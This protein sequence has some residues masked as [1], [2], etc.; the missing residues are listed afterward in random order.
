MSSLRPTAALT[1]G[2]LV[3]VLALGAALATGRVQVLVLGL[4]MLAW[5]VGA[6]AEHVLRRPSAARPEVRLRRATIP[7]QATTAVDVTAPAGLLVSTAWPPL[8][9]LDTAP[10]GRASV[11]TPSTRLR[12]T[13]RRW[14]RYELGPVRT[15]LTDPWGAFRHH[16]NLAC[17]PL[18]VVPD[19][20]SLEAGLEVP[21]PIGMSGPHLSRRRGDGTALADV[22]PFATGDR[23]ARINWRVTARTGHL[24]T[25]ATFTEQDTD[26][27]VVTDT[28]Q[29]VG[30]PTPAR[31]AASRPTASSPTSLDMTIRA[32]A[33]VARH[34]LAAGDRVAVHDAGTLIGDV[35]TGSG[36]RQVRRIITALSRARR[37]A[38]VLTRARP[39]RGLRSSTLV[40]V[41]TPLLGTPVIGLIGDALSQGAD[42]IV[43]DT[44]PP[45]LGDVQALRPRG[46]RDGGRQDRYWEEAWVL[47]RL[48]RDSVVRD[49]RERGVPVT[50]W[51]GP[52]SLTA[53]LMA[54]AAAG[55]APRMRR[56]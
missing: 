28:L 1:R 14:G 43:V 44:L 36:A 50:A 15:V 7:E 24:H 29:E 19:A 17:P 32:T 30:G 2:G 55:T 41:C 51:T 20:P 13:A 23:L 40:V 25:N 53:V 49:L 8:A 45:E 37:G 3:S 35:P 16:E 54:M 27:L 11:S 52:G 38:E 21:Q 18:S 46:R 56:A 34:Y 48:I 42:V 4:V 31:R 9:D 47:R 10:A 33:A 12:L 22:R 39:L 26:V 6:L 5:T